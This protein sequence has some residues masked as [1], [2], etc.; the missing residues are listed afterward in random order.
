MDKTQYGVYHLSDQPELYESQRD[1]NFEFI[2]TDI[3][4]LIRAGADETDTES[5]IVNAQHTLRYSVTEAFIPNFTQE[6]ITVSRGNS[7]IKAAGKPT[8]SEGSIVVNDFIGADTKSAL[9]AWQRLSYDVKTD[10]V[11][12]MANYKKTCY[13]LEYDPSFNLVRTWKLIGCFVSGLSE[14]SYNAESSGKKVITAT[15]AYDRAIPE[16]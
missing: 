7:V 8:F 10:T 12:S 9:M 11:G 5:I 6:V 1:N 14:N 3:D 15:I 13:L 16:V 4:N 2:I